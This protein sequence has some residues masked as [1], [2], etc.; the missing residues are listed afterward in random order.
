MV[1][2]VNAGTVKGTIMEGQQALF[3][4]Y[5]PP[6]HLNRRQLAILRQCFDAD[7]SRSTLVYILILTSIDAKLFH[8]F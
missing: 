8:S 1:L 5:P 7:Y 4:Y 6:D 2:L 3:H